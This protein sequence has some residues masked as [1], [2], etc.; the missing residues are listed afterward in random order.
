[1]SHECFVLHIQHK[2]KVHDTKTQVYF[3]HVNSSYSRARTL[4]TNTGRSHTE[5][6]KI[7]P[8]PLIYKDLRSYWHLVNFWELFK[9]RNRFIFINE[10]VSGGPPEIIWVIQ[11]ARYSDR[12][13]WP[14][15]LARLT[16]GTGDRWS[17]A[18]AGQIFFFFFFGG[19]PGGSG[20][21][22]LDMHFLNF[23]QKTLS[24]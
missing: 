1:M 6:L 18:G 19:T 21:L 8:L 16:T 11:T 2:R 23:L 15:G 3:I 22:T 10:F 13:R 24:P 4:P 17:I 12:S 5:N 9:R 20:Q 14:S 7:S